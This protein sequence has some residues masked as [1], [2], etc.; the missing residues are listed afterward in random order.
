M[1]SEKRTVGENQLGAPLESGYGLDDVFPI[2]NLED[3]AII[4]EKIQIDKQLR[5]H[6]VSLYKYIFFS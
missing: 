4:N 1:N 3:L 6:L 5:L 2:T